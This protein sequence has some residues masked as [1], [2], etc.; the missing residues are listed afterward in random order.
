[1]EQD[2]HTAKY[3]SFYQQV[4]QT[5]RSERGRKNNKYMLQVKIKDANVQSLRHTFGIHHV[6]SGAR[7]KTVQEMMGYRDSPTVS[8]YFALAKD[9]IIKRDRNMLCKGDLHGFN[10]REKRMRRVYLGENK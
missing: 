6:V 9:A 3:S 8:S 5:I 1:M 2:E 10:I 4:W 7:L